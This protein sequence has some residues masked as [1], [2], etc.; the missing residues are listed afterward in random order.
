MN[1]Y[2]KLSQYDKALD[3]WKK[4]ITDAA[5]EM[6]GWLE[7]VVTDLTEDMIVMMTMMMM[8]IYASLYL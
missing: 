8:P 2:K 4:M 7:A 5:C 1:L 3:P 6:T